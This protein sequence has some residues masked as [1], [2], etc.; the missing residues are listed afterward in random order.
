MRSERKG[1]FGNGM[2]WTR[3]FAILL[4]TTAFLVVGVCVGAAFAA[5]AAGVGVTI[6][7]P[8]DYATI[9][10]AVENAS[11]GDT[12]VVR[13]GTYEENVLLDKRLTLVGEGLPTIDAE[14][15][16]DAVKITADY[17]L[18]TGFRCVNARDSAGIKVESDW[19]RIEKNTC[20]Q[21]NF[22]VCLPDSS[23]NTVSENDLSENEYGIY[24]YNS[25]SPFLVEVRVEAPQC[26]E[27]AGTFTATV[28]VS[29][30]TNFSSA[31]F[32]L[33]FNSSVVKI[34]DVKDG[35]IGG[36]TVPVFGWAFKPGSTDSVIVIISMPPGEVVSGSGHLAEV[37]FK[38]K[39]EEGDESVLNIFNGVLVGIHFTD[40]LGIEEIPTVWVN[41]VI[42]VGAD[43]AE[44]EEAEEEKD[45]AELLP[46]ATPVLK[47]LSSNNLF[48][49]NSIS[50]S[51]YGIYLLS[52]N[53]NT[54]SNNT[55]SSKNENCSGF[56]T[57]NGVSL[58]R[59]TNNVITKNKISESKAEGIWFWHS[60][61]NEIANNQIFE[62][63]YSGVYLRYSPKNKVSNNEINRNNWDGVY[64][65]ESRNNTIKSN[66][67]YENGDDGI[68]LR[69]RSSNCEITE[70]KIRG[71]N[72]HGICLGSSNRV[73]NNKIYDNNGDGIRLGSS[74][75]VTN[76]EIY[77][78]NGD[79]I[80][81]SGSSNCIYLNDFV[82][83]GR[84]VY[85]HKSDNL[86]NSPME[87]SY[88]YEGTNYTGYLGNYWSD[89][90]GTDT[91]RDGIGDTPYDIYEPHDEG[92]ED[93]FDYHPLMRSF[94]CYFSEQPEPT[95]S[96]STDKTAYSTGNRMT[97]AI[98]IAN[99][100]E[101]SVT[102]QW[103]WGV[104]QYNI[105]APVPVAF[106][107]IPAGYDETH[108]FN[109]TIPNWGATP[110]G[111]LFYVQLLG[112]ESESGSVVADAACWVYSPAAGA[113]GGEG[114]KEARGK[115][116][117]NLELLWDEKSSIQDY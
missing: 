82:S 54:F 23:N 9:Q 75:R 77:D 26:V 115:E 68:H 96:I 90:E 45:E 84:N 50:N 40:S 35:K 15:K 66:E 91:D 73:T 61:K 80:H 97:V 95:V 39:G 19:N 22:G 101:E 34:T 57:G 55:V 43:E 117:N 21:N 60:T 27:E 10:W 112:E 105:W 1:K 24:L 106:S 38:V 17:C 12:I 49:N 81:L 65:Y 67:I 2:V 86:W 28:D 94:E 114:G 52:S 83:N 116:Q 32:E 20:E 62:N 44:E 48:S 88:I 70:N 25:S 102:F 33:S 18:V 36:E 7:V 78:N 100:T 87:I 69:W 51:S 56:C 89:Y 37:E 4:A 63:Y 93:D 98:E 13:E 79:G 11:A 74:N 8:D 47:P 110:F 5:A 85:S 111:N 108:D 58:V 16:G 99:P 3:A 109:F 103:F 113:G 71:N 42:R 64:L 46:T 53:N 107:Q 92:K 72:R 76:N 30:V 29:A 31:Q 59:S 14:G 41:A 6:F 104:P